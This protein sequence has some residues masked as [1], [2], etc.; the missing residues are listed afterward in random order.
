MS[1]VRAS[2]VTIIIGSVLFMTA[3]LSPISR[4]FGTPDPARKLEIITAAPNQWAVA[5]LLFALGAVVTVV[6]VGMLALR[7]SGQAFS[8]WLH[9]AVVLMGVGALLWSQHVWQRAA[10]P[11][12]F[13]RGDI[14]VWWFAVY[15][16]LTLAG[17]AMIGAALLQTDL[18][19]WLGRLAIGSAAAFLVLGLVFGDM[20]PFVY[21]IITLT[22]GIVLYRASE[23][24]VL[25]AQ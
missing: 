2:A 17:L 10:D 6:G 1:P 3:A 21:Y 19:A 25:A 9:G 15:S 16:L 13:T 18:P 20:P 23:I 4:V 24:G 11:A 7:T 22:I 14:A 8:P 12:A 5:Q